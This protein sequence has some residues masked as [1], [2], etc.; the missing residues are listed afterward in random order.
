MGVLKL[1]PEKLEKE[2]G[3]IKE[4]VKTIRSDIPHIHR[5]LEKLE[6]STG[7]DS[8]FLVVFPCLTVFFACLSGFCLYVGNIP[9][10]IGA[11]GPMGASLVGA[12]GLYKKRQGPKCREE[13]KT[14]K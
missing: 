14:F 5:R 11:L 9:L 1:D 8:R 6:R 13:F 7:L 3:G 12:I 4:D 2:I 10:A